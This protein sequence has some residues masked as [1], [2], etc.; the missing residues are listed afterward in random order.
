GTVTNEN[1][2]MV[3]AIHY[4]PF[5]EVWLEEVPASLPVDYFFTA[6]ELD[7]E[8]G[9]YD[10][11]ARY[12]DP[13]FSK[14]MT[15]DPALKDYLPDARQTV[16]YADPSFANNWQRHLNLPSRGG[17]FAPVN[18]AVYGYGQY[19]PATLIDLIGREI[20]ATSP[21]AQQVLDRVEA[22]P[23][24]REIIGV[25]RDDKAKWTF[26]VGND[27]PE[28]RFRYDE[29]YTNPAYTNETD[30]PARSLEGVIVPPKSVN[31]NPTA[32]SKYEV[33][34]H[35]QKKAWYDFFPR[36]LWSKE[37]AER[38]AGHELAHAYLFVKHGAAAQLL[39]Y[40]NQ[41]IDIEN[42]IAT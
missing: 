33:L 23:K 8:T 34:M 7:Q 22:T 31:I 5:G 3:D 27:I 39:Y 19:N 2:Q 29:K 20:V 4:F 14:W 42:E 26:N 30:A 24:G 11:G 40:Q 28:L 21:L 38:A 6:K 36:Y 18:I 25:L 15:A 13:R 41:T 17:V 1:S 16:G 12:L 32:M 10:F 35:E 9:F 37:S